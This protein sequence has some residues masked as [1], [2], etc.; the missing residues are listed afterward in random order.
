MGLD[1]KQIILILLIVLLL[2]GAKRIPELARKIGEGIN[3][4]KKGISGSGEEQSSDAMASDVEA[5]EEKDI[6]PSPKALPAAENT[7]AIKKPSSKK[8]Q[9]SK[10]TKKSTTKAQKSSSK[11]TKVAKASKSKSSKA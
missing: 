8:A 6:T 11:S 10:T 7:S 9:A 3:E 2:F 4:F 1:L 5:T